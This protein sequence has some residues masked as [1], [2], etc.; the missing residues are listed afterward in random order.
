MLYIASNRKLISFLISD[1]LGISPKITKITLKPWVH[2][3]LIDSKTFVGIFLQHVL[4]QVFELRR[5]I[6]NIF[7]Y[8]PITRRVAA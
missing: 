7:K 3:N 8:L 6:G 2:L 5:R 1:K 4:D